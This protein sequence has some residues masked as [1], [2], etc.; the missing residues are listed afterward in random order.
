MAEYDAETAPNINTFT[1]RKLTKKQKIRANHNKYSLKQIQSR[2]FVEPVSA[3]VIHGNGVVDIE[4]TGSVYGIQ[5]KYSG[6]LHITSKH[7][8]P[9][10]INN[11][12]TDWIMAANNST[13]TLLYFSFGGQA[14]S[15][16]NTLFTYRGN[17]KFTDIVISG[18]NTQIKGILSKRL[19]DVFGE[20]NA[21][22][23]KI[24]VSFKN[25]KDK[26]KVG[27]GTRKNTGYE[28]KN[29][30]SKRKKTLKKGIGG[31]Y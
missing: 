20:I 19:T 11:G 13:G 24:N 29:N 16:K 10:N 15:G 7:G 23:N 31:S 4:V 1:K 6:D 21:P 22:F 2:D 14:I 26:G 17:P 9:N 25:L 27:L 3:K 28:L 12:S 30:K 18:K 5:M 8:D